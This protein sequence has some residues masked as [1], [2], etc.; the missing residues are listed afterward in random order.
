MIAFILRKKGPSAKIAKNLPSPCPCGHTINFKKS[1]VFCAKKCERP[2]LKNPLVCTGQPLLTADVFSGRLVPN[3]SF[4]K[5]HLKICHYRKLKITFTLTK[6]KHSMRRFG[7]L[8]YFIIYIS[9]TYFGC[10]LLIRLFHIHKSNYYAPKYLF[11]MSKQQQ[12]SGKT[13]EATA[14]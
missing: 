7:L 13:S 10:F 8:P 9:R 3:T 1:D 4:S 2:H 12:Y 5:L 11:P 6:I 14:L